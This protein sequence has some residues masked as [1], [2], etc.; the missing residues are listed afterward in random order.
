MSQ[1]PSLGEDGARAL[2]RSG[3]RGEKRQCQM[4][5]PYPTTWRL[6][7]VPMDLLVKHSLVCR[8]EHTCEVFANF[9]QRFIP[10]E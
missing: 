7:A 6:P 2:L 9:L 10:P 8:G 4:K 1:L 3:S 5:E